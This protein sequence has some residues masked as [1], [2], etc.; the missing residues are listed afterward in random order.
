MAGQKA[1][2]RRLDVKC[3]GHPKGLAIDEFAFGVRQNPKGQFLY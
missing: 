1:R 3:S 2:E